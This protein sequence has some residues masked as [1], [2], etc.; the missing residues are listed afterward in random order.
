MDLAQV[1][2]NKLKQRGLG[3]VLLKLSIFTVLAGPMKMFSRKQ[4]Q[5]DKG[6]TL[7]D[8]TDLCVHGFWLER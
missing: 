6:H 3:C 5:S 1:Q 7:C 2:G 4:L 8:I